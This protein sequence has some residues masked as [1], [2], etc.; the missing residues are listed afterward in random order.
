[1]LDASRGELVGTG[2][3][4]L[5]SGESWSTCTIVGLKKESRYKVQ[6]PNNTR[7]RPAENAYKKAGKVSESVETQ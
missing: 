5:G 3:L 6:R 1:M 2:R 7:L 4:H